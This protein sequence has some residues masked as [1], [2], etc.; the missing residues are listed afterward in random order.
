MNAVK[1]FVKTW[2]N[3]GYEKG[4][5]QKFWL[6]FLRYV[7]Q[8]DK[9]EKYV[10]FEVPVKLEHTNYI[11]AFFPDTKV[12]VEQKSLQKNL[13]EKILQS[14]KNFLTPYEQAQKYILGLPLSMHP[15]F[16]VVC[17][18][19]EFLIYDMEYKVGRVGEK[20]TRLRLPHRQ[21]KK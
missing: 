3:R 16:I 1:N 2:Q 7:L 17:N 19:Q 20:I 9:P 4:D 18:F 13:S 21:N 11:D 5:T 12:I 10:E 14:D 8:V 6:M 15:R